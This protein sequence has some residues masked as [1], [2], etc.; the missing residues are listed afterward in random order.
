VSGRLRIAR[1]I[2]ACVLAFACLQAAHATE[3]AE[4]A[5]MLEVSVPEYP[6]AARRHEQ[7]GTVRVRV[8]VLADGQATDIRVEK[9]SGS[10]ELDRAAVAAV[11]ASKFRAARSPEGVP[12]DSWVIVPY[13]FVLQD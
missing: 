8:R 5:K 2:G 10:A 4:P 6:A 11:N 12:V 13:Q 9:S 3:A 7:E 1:R